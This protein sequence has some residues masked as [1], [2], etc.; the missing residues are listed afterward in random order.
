MTAPVAICT[1]VDDATAADICGWFP[2]ADADWLSGLVMSGWVD[3]VSED[4]L[5]LVSFRALSA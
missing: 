1:L 5:E 2:A 4:C 3:V